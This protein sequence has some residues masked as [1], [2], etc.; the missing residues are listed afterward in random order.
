[1]DQG[2]PRDWWDAESD[3]DA[4]VGDGDGQVGEQG[5]REQASG[6]ETER[7]NSATMPGHEEE[8]RPGARWRG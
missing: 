6:Q 2:R 1:M 8:G 3:S 5:L 4:V 7:V